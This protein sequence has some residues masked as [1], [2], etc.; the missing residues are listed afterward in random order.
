[1]RFWDLPG[2]RSFLDEVEGQLRNNKNLI[3]ALPTP[4]PPGFMNAFRDQLELS[5]LDLFLLEALPGQ[6][7][8]DLLF[9]QLSIDIAP[10]EKPSPQSF[11]QNLKS[12]QVIIVDGVFRDMWE[13]WWNF[14]SEYELLSREIVAV[15]RPLLVCIVSGVEE[16]ILPRGAVA[17]STNVWKG[18]LSEL[19]M[20]TYAGARIRSRGL[21]SAH[22]RLVATT[23]A[24]IAQWDVS[25]AD[26]LLDSEDK[27]LFSPQMILKELAQTYGWMKGAR[28]SWENGIVDYFDGR[29]QIHSAFLALNDPY[30]ELNMRVWSSQASTLLPMIEL[31]RRKLVLK[32]QHKL[33]MPLQ[34]GDERISDPLDLE[35]GILSHVAGIC[36]VDPK[37]CAKLRKLKHIRNALAHL[38]VLKPEMALDQDILLL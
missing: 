31:H 25:I 23:V 1:M 38:E 36:R 29:E 28:A 30:D 26:V 5:W 19:D 33:K 15:D 7:P 8:I 9:E 37:I 10:T 14:I 21:E 22:F 18:V 27:D 35:I 24:R 16:T 11:V 6:R 32:I 13:D 2:P 4:S 34:V 3:I 20:L 17:L 12:G